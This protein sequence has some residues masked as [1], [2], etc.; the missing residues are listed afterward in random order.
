MKLLIF[1]FIENLLTNL[2]YVIIN[3]LDFPDETK[4]FEDINT[5]IGVVNISETIY[6]NGIYDFSIKASIE[7]KNLS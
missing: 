1:K 3:T 4:Y 7:W 6:S 2:K 5:A